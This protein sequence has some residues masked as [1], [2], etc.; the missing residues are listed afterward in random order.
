VR[1]CTKREVTKEEFEQFLAQNQGLR[2][3]GMRYTAPVKMRGS[4][5]NKPLAAVIDG[6]FF[7]IEDK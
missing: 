2:F 4:T 6:K 3:D 7:L 1:Y 5:W